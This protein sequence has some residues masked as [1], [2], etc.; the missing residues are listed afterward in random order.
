MNENTA[1]LV[2]VVDDDESLRTATLRLLAAA[3]LQARGYATAGEVLLEPLPEGA[4]C[5]VLDLRMPGPSGL[6]LQAALQRRGDELPIIFLTG[7]GDVHNGVQAMKAGAVDFLTKPVQR[8]TLLAAVQRALA[9]GETRA[10]ARAELAQLRQRFETLSA[11]ER[12]V[13]DQVAA[14]RLNKQIAFDLGLAERTVKAE[15][16]SVMAKLGVAS[17]AELGQIAER[18][19]HHLPH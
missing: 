12:E 7:H 4:G 10:A 5:M 15:R 19:R 13:F 2:L 3:G 6:D 16:A 14:G 9:L 17:A 1:P 18:L 8:D 11:R